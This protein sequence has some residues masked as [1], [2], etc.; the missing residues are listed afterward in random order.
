VGDFEETRC[1]GYGCT[2]DNPHSHHTDGSVDE[3]AYRRGF[4]QGS[5]MALRA[6]EA[7]ISARD[8]ERWRSAVY[9]WRFKVSHK[10]R[11]QPP[12]AKGLYG[13]EGGV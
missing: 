10:K 12:R 1:G 7:G 9:R 3:D 13:T 2:D 5:E 6:V 11:V 8:L 4:Q